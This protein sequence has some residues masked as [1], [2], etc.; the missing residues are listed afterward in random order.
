MSIR[1]CCLI[2]VHQPQMQQQHCVVGNWLDVV[3]TRSKA[4]TVHFIS[5]DSPGANSWGLRNS[6]LYGGGNCSTKQ[7]VWVAKKAR[8]T[9]IR[10]LFIVD[11]EGGFYEGWFCEVVRI[12]GYWLLVSRWWIG[13]VAMVNGY[14]SLDNLINFLEVWDLHIKE[15]CLKSCWIDVGKDESWCLAIVESMPDDTLTQRAL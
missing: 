14:Q 6:I 11:S 1:C 8:C 10:E 4:L 5:I 12:G 9:I 2:S 3:K 7:G 15:L 13:F